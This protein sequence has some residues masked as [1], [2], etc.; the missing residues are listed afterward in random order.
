MIVLRKNS[1]NFGYKIGTSYVPVESSL[2]SYLCDEIW[3]EKGVSFEDF[4]NIILKYHEEYSTVFYSHLS[5]VPLSDFLPEWNELP[6]KNIEPDGMKKLIISWE[7]QGIF[8]DSELSDKEHGLEIN[9]LP[10]FGGI[11]IG[12]DGNEE[13]YAVEFTP[14]NELKKY[15]LEILINS[16]VYNYKTD[17][18][19]VHIDRGFTV[20]EIL[21]AIFYEITFVGNP[22]DREKKSDELISMAYEIGFDKD[23]EPSSD[24]SSSLDDILKKCNIDRPENTV[25]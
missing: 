20:Y 12:K 2:I 25:D 5:G 19:L 3:I 24:S 7:K 11:G 17:K 21:S 13:G 16:T 10:S 23:K 4:F 22:K 6:E 18:I 8:K 9:W 15:P 1:N 14:L